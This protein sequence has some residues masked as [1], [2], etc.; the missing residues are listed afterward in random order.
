MKDEPRKQTNKHDTREGWLRSATDAVR[1]YFALNGYEIPAR[2]RFSI[3]FP[4]TGKAGK[5]VG[6]VWLPATS[7]DES[8]E[9]FIRADIDAPANVLGILVHELIHTVLPPDAGHGKLYKDAA[10]K[11]GL[12]GPMRHAM[13]GPLL[14]ARLVEIADGLGP[15]PHARLDLSRARDGRLIAD[16]PKKQKARLLKAECGDEACGYNVRVVAKWVDEVGPPHCPKHGAMVLET[17]ADDEAETAEPD[18][19]APHQEKMETV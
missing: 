9:L 19:S 12:V 7:A 6:E 8:C 13:P 2:I 11:L 10:H 18:E 15:L 3:G 4:S 14:A 5:R 16:R 1:E 17:R